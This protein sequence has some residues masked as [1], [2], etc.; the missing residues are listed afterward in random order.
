M[1]ESSKEPEKHPHRIDDGFG[2]TGAKPTCPGKDEGADRAG[3]VGVGV[4]AQCGD[5]V[6]HHGYVVGQ[7]TFSD[8]T[9]VAHPVA[10]SYD[11]RGHGFWLGA[12]SG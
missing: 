5:K 12:S 9:G 10:E 4:F 6:H 8:A 11:Q 1:A 7:R 3:V 2:A